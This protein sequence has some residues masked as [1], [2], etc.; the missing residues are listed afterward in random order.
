MQHEPAAA[1]SPLTLEEFQELATQGVPFVGLLGCRVERFAP[2]DVVVRLPWAEHLVRPG[3]TVCGPAMMALADI[4]LYGLVLSRIGRV[5]LAGHGRPHLPLPAQ[6]APG[7]PDRPGTAAA[8]G[9][10]ARGGRG[11]DLQ[12]GRA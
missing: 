2:G 12:R 7:R 11:H 6:A 1:P 8:P 3:G 9:P 10:V 5:E 4:V